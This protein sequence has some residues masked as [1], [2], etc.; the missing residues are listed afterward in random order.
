MKKSLILKLIIAMLSLASLLCFAIG[1]GGGTVAPSH[2][3]E[4]NQKVTSSK[5]LESKATCENKAK[6][7]YSCTCGEK[8][9][10]S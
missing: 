1:C 4:F 6:Y 10:E 9:E 2:Q 3:H 7:Y 5:Y 8:G